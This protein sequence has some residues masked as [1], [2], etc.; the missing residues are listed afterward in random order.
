MSYTL[1]IIKLGAADLD[2]ATALDITGAGVTVD[3]S[4]S[5]RITVTV[6]DGTAL[7]TIDPG[8]VLEAAGET[9]H[10]FEL[11]QMTAVSNALYSGGTTNN[12]QRVIGANAES[13][14]DLTAENGDAL[15]GKLWFQ[16]EV[17]VAVNTDV[18]GPH[19]LN[20]YLKQV[21]DEDF[22]GHTLEKP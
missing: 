17:L 5:G 21:E 20:I 22:A 9:G 15:R 7:G 13:L 1:R 6:P 14:I 19:E 4:L 18:G 3:R 2:G 11:L 16:P 10:T 12:I 8:G